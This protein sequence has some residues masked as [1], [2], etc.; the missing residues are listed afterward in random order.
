MP[1][2]SEPREGAAAWRS[3][4][5][6]EEGVADPPAPPTGSRGA[7]R[8]GELIDRELARRLAQMVH[9]EAVKKE[10]IWRGILRRARAYRRGYRIRVLR[11]P[12][13]VAEHRQPPRSA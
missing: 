8:E 12:P 13:S 10:K 4:L 1:A 7:L 5:T 9:E 3:T 6:D 11:A 2:P